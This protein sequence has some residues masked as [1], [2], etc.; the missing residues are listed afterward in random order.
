MR[1]YNLITHLSLSLSVLFSCVQS[2]NEEECAGNDVCTSV[3]V[4]FNPCIPLA[5]PRD[6]AH[7]PHSYIIPTRNAPIQLFSDRIQI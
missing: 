3:A 7:Q 1:A 5:W 4:S 2:D 6:Y